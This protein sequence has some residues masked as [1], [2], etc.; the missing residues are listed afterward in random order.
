MRNIAS[1]PESS[2]IAPWAEVVP[3]VGPM[4]VEDLEAWPDDGWQYEL[5]GGVLVRMPFSGHQASNIAVRL[6]VRLG[7]YVE[8]HELG[9]VTGA[10]GGFRPDPAHP[11]DTELAPDVAF[12]RADRL[13]SRTSPDYTRALRLAPDLAV[14]VV[15]PSQSRRDLAVKARLY[16]SFG[17]RLVW[18][19]L[20]KQRQVDVFRLGSNEPSTLGVDDTL[21]G[22][23]VV[24][25]FSY[26][27]AALFR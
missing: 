21:D 26:P 15:S 12:V 5:V 25:G 9:E 24:P 8:D 4:T 6:I 20:P 23:D 14:E 11:R 7:A 1:I 18:V 22:E 17:T 16:L 2:A 27:V 19:V 3:G 10:D 13:P